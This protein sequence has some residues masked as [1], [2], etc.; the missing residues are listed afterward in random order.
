MSKR[1]NELAFKYNID[2]RTDELSLF[3]SEIYDDGFHAGKQAQQAFNTTITLR[4]YFASLAMQS[5]YLSGV[6]WETTGKER[7]EGSLA[8]IK[9]LA[10]DAYQLADAM[11]GVRGAEGRKTHCINYDEIE[12][13]LAQPEQDNTQYLLDQ[14]SRLTAENAM[15]KE[16]WSPPKFEPLGLEIMDVC[17]SEDYR[18]GFKDGALYAEKAHGI[19]E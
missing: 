14:V 6:E 4:D 9:E 2:A 8:V 16:K 5:L 15:L 19:T 18:E 3:V 12:Q 13:L 1:I 7:D 10:C 11:L 17:G